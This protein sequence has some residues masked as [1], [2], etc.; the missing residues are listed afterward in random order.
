MR[1]LEDIDGALCRV[2]LTPQLPHCAREELLAVLLDYVRPV[3]E[4]EG[5][6]RCAI[7]ERA[8]PCPPRKL[9]HHLRHLSPDQ[10]AD[11]RLFKRKRFRAAEALA[12]ATAERR[13]PSA[14]SPDTPAA[15]APC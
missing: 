2:L 1:A 7:P 9:P 15:P 4:R 8:L 5:R 10:L 12:I 13:S 6:R 14:P 3:L 11:Y